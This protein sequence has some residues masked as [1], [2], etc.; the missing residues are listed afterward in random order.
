MVFVDSFYL[1]LVVVEDFYRSPLGF[2]SNLLS[3]FVPAV[4]DT[5]H[6]LKTGVACGISEFVLPGNFVPI[7]GPSNPFG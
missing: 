4:G 6:F 5:T 3:A 7:E 2:D 1:K